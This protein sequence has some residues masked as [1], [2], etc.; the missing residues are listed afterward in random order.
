MAATM[1]RTVLPVVAE[2]AP[3]GKLR[4]YRQVGN[5][6]FAQGNF[7]GASAAYQQAAD[8]LGEAP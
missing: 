5:I 2:A 6:A 8:V 1:Y 4:L 7:Q 3:S